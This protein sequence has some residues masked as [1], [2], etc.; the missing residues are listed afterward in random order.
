MIA[1]AETEGEWRGRCSE[2]IQESI[3]NDVPITDT[4]KAIGGFMHKNQG[5]FL[6][7][8][9]I[10]IEIINNGTGPKIY[11]IRKSTIDTIDETDTLPLMNAETADKYKQF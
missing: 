6:A 2:I 1:I 10:K 5:R 9:G 7:E 11:K 8:D 3:L 4:P